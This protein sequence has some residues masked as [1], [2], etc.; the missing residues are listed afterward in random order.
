[1]LKKAE[2]LMNLGKTHLQKH[3][4]SVNQSSLLS[5]ISDDDDEKAAD[6][7]DLHGMKEFG[8]YLASIIQNLKS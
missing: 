1:M 4:V 8:K 2:T 7:T 3:A 6:G 5:E